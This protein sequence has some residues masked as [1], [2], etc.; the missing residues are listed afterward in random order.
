[1]LPGGGLIIDTPGMRELQLWDV[2]TAMGETF[3]DVEALAAGC[4]FT[5]CRHRGEPRCA[6]AAAVAGGVLDAHRLESYLKLKDEVARLGREQEDRA[7]IDQRRR[8]R[9]PGKRPAQ[10]R[11]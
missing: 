4:H 10:K 7:R 6:V 2:G 11:L 5:D 3:G 8:S 9:T 1:V